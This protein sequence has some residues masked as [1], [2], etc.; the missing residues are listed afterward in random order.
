MQGTLSPEA[1]GVRKDGIRDRVSK[2]RLWV[3][4]RDE[5]WESED[6]SGKQG[7]TAEGRRQLADKAKKSPH[8]SLTYL[9]LLDNPP[10]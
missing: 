2:G 8:N 4:E 10:K 1:V 3:V 9:T 7:S 5:H 6:V